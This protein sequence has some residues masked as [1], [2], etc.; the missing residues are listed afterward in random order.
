[1]GKGIAL[2]F[3][4]SSVV[5]VLAASGCVNKLC[6]TEWSPLGKLESNANPEKACQIACDRVLSTDITRLNEL[7]ECECGKSNC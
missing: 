1:M 7:G 4:I 3:L 2:L 6:T 5:L